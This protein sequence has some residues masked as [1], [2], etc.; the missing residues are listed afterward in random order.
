MFAGDGVGIGHRQRF[1]RQDFGEKLV[2]ER[3]PFGWGHLGC[4]KVTTSDRG[5]WRQDLDRLRVEVGGGY[6]LGAPQ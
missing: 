5:R 3:G 4:D 2:F 1:P 6:A